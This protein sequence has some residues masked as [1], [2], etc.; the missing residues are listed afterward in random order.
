VLGDGRTTSRLIKILR[1]HPNSEDRKFAAYALGLFDSARAT[2]A[3]REALARKSEVAEVRA[4]AAEQLVY[5]SAAVQDLINGLRDPNRE[6]R[7]WCAYA[8][9]EGRVKRALPR[10]RRLTADRARVAGW[11]SVGREAKWAIAT[12]EA[13]WNRSA[14]YPAGPVKGR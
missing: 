7:F 14:A 13:G 9:G 4:M 10:L 8:L 6:V 3:L 2:D 5:R 11:W 1:T 12:I